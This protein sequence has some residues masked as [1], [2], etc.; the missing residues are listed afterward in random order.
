MKIEHSFRKMASPFAVRIDVFAEGMYEVDIGRLKTDLEEEVRTIE[1]HFSR[2][3]AT[4]ELTELNGRVGQTTEI[5]DRFRQVLQLTEQAHSITAGAFDPRV[6]R[7]LERLGYPGAPLPQG[8]LQEADARSAKDP[9]FLWRGE[10]RIELSAPIDLGGIVKGYAADCL[11]DL[12]ES[13]IPEPLLAGFIVNAGGDVVLRGAQESGESWSIGVEN[14]FQPERIL[15]ALS[16]QGE[17][18]SV[19]TSSVWRK[20]WEMEGRRVHHL[21]DPESGEPVTSQIQS[22]T[23]MAQSA[24]FAEVLTKYVFVR[25][26]FPPAVDAFGGLPRVLIVNGNR[27]LFVT[28]DFSPYLSWVDPAMN[29]TVLGEL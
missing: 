26:S 13:R 10:R 25:G 4:S 21:I 8:I 7:H 27:S 3:E 28:G 15:A 12:I 22:V 1:Q 2:F 11:A 17:K 20:S 29:T 24:A 9:L 6:I 23:A 5:S 14:P 18:R 19:C 16:I